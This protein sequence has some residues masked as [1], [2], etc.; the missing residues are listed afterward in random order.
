MGVG[1]VVRR[2]GRQRVIHCEPLYPG[3][4]AGAG[5]GEP[6]GSAG[7]LDEAIEVAGRKR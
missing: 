1:K 3:N 6:N 2:K 7:S 4:R 5:S